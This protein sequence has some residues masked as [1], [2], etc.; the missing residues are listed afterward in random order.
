MPRPSFR[1]D[2]EDEDENE[3]TDET[4]SLPEA[5]STWIEEVIRD[6]VQSFLNYLWDDGGLKDVLKDAVREGASEAVEDVA[7]KQPWRHLLGGEKKS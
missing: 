5:L 4:S 6:E 7:S 2:D 3:D 1:D